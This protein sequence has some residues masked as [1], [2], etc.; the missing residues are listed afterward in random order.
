MMG[1][2]GVMGDAVAIGDRAC[3]T[4]YERWGGTR[5]QE[6]EREREVERGGVREE[7]G[8]RRALRK[9][10]GSINDINEQYLRPPD[11]Q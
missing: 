11:Q 5:E 3:I 9:K 4:S 8:R 6:R 1:V 7:Q 2:I 10:A